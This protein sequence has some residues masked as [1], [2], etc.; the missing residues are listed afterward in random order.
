MNQNFYLTVFISAC[1]SSLLMSIFLFLFILKVSEIKN[2]TIQLLPDESELKNRPIN[3]LFFGDIMLG[4]HVK[5]VMDKNGGVDYLLTKIAG[6]EKRFFQGIDIIM[7]NLEGAVT[8]NG[9]HYAP[10]ISID[11]AF[12]PEDVKQLKNYGFNF[13]GISNNHAL[14]QNWRGFAETQENLKNSGFDFVGCPDKTVGEC[15]IKIK[16]IN[17]IKIGMLAYSMVY[18]VLDEEKMLAQIKDLKMQSD[19]V[20]VNMHWGVEYESQT[21]SNIKELAH[22]IIDAGADAI[23]G[24]HPHV[25]Q[26]IEIY[27]GKPIFYSLGNFIFDQYFSQETQEGL[28]VGATWQDN[29]MQIDLFPF[30]SEKS[31][32][33]LMI[34]ERK[35]KFLQWLANISDVSEEYKEQIESGKINF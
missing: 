11:F 28:A 19:L 23:I 30:Y 21:R 3:F 6:E 13:F 29:K 2:Q 25:V 18:G 5:E 14:D 33:A 12:N 16:E 26:N 20:I 7:A 15:S 4:R 27:N 31:Q 22:N 34:D 35:Q 8:N 24:H 10:E 1:I 9:A 17:G 32:P